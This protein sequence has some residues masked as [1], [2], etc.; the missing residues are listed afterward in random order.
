MV[1]SSLIFLGINCY[2]TINPFLL[3]KH[4]RLLFFLSIPPCPLY[5]SMSLGYDESTVKKL[6]KVTKL[7]PESIIHNSS[8][9]TKNQELSGTWLVLDF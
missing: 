3:N 4:S 1:C 7:I 2:E 9:R 5:P 6:Q 8:S